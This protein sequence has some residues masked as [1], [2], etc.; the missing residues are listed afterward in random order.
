MAAA[1]V[2]LAVAAYEAASIVL[3]VIIEQSV[4]LGVRPTG[5]TLWPP[6]LARLAWQAA[7]L[8]LTQAV[9]A[10]ATLMALAARSVE[11]RGIVYD[12]VRTP[13]RVEVRPR[14]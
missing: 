6:S 14:P 12:I 10:V 11:W 9:Y 4:R 3:V 8:P 1:L 2:L 13:E 7:V 5:R